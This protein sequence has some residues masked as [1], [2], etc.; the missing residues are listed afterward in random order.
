M[1]VDESDKNWGDK[2]KLVDQLWSGQL[3]HRIRLRGNH[4]SSIDAHHRQ[5]NGRQ[6]CEKVNQEWVHFARRLGNQTQIDFEINN[7]EYLT[8]S[9]QQGEQ[10][11]QGQK[12]Q[13]S[14][15]GVAPHRRLEK[16]RNWYQIADQT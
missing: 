14:E 9:S 3:A 16:Y 15:C 4:K 5:H 13:V 11:E 8:V 7:E 1:W 12:C 6:V 10:I 2:N